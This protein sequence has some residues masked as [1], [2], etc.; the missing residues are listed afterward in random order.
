MDGTKPES[1]DDDR[2]LERESD[3]KE[4]PKERAAM[5]VDND[6]GKERAQGQPRQAE[7]TIKKRQ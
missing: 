7:T 2:H 5:I 6:N 4:E 1:S 3:G